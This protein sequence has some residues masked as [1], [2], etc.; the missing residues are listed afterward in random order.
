MKFKMISYR[1]GSIMDFGEAVDAEGIKKFVEE[2]PNADSFH[3]HPESDGTNYFLS[4]YRV[5]PRDPVLW[6]KES[7]I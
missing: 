4:G 6:Q 3:A 5:T 1:R 7:K 2:R